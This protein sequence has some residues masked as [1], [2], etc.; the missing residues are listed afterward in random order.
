MLE[1][2]PVADLLRRDALARRS[3][4]RR[5]RRA[6]RTRSRWPASVS[7]RDAAE[8]REREQPVVLDVRDRDADLVDV[9]DERERRRALAGADARERRAERVASAPRRTPTAASRQ[10]ARGS[11]SWPDGPEAIRRRG[12]ELGSR[13]SACA[14]KQERLPSLAEMTSPSRTLVGLAPRAG[15]EP[16]RV[17]RDRRQPAPLDPD[18][19]TR[20]VFRIPMTAT[21]VLD[22]DLLTPLG[23]YLHLRAQRPRRASCSS[24]SSRAGSAATRSS[25]AAT[26]LVTFEE[27]ERCDEPVVGYLGY[28][29]V[30]KLEPTVPLPDDGPRPAREP[31]RRRRH[32]RPLRPRRSARRGA[33]GRSRR[34]RRAA[35]RRRAAA[36]ARAR[37]P[38]RRRRAA[39]D[40]GRVRARRRALQGAHPARRRVP[41][42]PLAAR[43]AARPASPA[44]ALYR[45]LR[46]VNPSPYLFLLELDGV[47]LVGSS[48]ETLVKREGTR[49]S[50]EPDRRLDAARARAT[51]SGC[52][53]PRR[54]APST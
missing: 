41:D 42:R 31:V 47:A 7:A 38:R 35:R 40:A 15:R 32:A 3:R 20:V 9:A 5:G 50:R 48:P 30:A 34:G 33:R 29:H 25:A 26:R 10:T 36:A 22:T 1:P 54:I 24:R 52:S 39:P 18:D 27:A 43:R 21:T 12:Q 23:A 19:P 46:R 14:F 53:R 49:A 17:E 4:R 44:L 11:S 2:R 8:R 28:D 13:P 6:S 16:A 45:S 51:P 37:Q